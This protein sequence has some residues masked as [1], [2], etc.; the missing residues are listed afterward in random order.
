M[1]LSISQL[2]L[3]LLGVLFKIDRGL[4]HDVHL[5]HDGVELSDING[6]DVS[7]ELTKHLHHANDQGEA[8]PDRGSLLS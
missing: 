5:Q 2:L 7:F 4:P 8:P 6:R 3:V 1:F